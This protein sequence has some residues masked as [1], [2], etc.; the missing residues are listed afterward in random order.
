MHKHTYT[1]IFP[2]SLQGRKGHAPPHPWPALTREEP[3]R[4]PQHDHYHVPYPSPGPCSP[5]ASPTS[6]SWP[7]GSGI[8]QGGCWLTTSQGRNG[9][10]GKHTHTHTHRAQGQVEAGPAS[11]SPCCPTLPDLCRHTRPPTRPHNTTLFVVLKLLPLGGPPPVPSHLFTLAQG[12][13]QTSVISSSSSASSVS[14]SASSSSSDVTSGSSAC[15]RHLGHE[16][17]NK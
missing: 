3:Q 7:L 2:S 12:Q 17:V 10:A 8:W 15:A 13:D 14:P 5:S 9:W 4:W 11:S 1:H 6:T 16:Q